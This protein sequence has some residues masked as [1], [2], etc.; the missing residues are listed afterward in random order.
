MLCATVLGVGYSPIMPGTMGTLAAVPLAIG[1]IFVGV[2]AL[3][4]RELHRRISEHLTEGQSLL[5]AARQQ[6]DAVDKLRQQAFQAFDS[7]RL[8]DGERTWAQALSLA[9]EN[10]KALGRV[11]QVFEGVLTLDASSRAARDLLAETLYQRAL[12]AERDRR[13]AQLED[14]LQ[15]LALYDPEG[16]WLQRHKAPGR[17]QLL[18]EPAGAV[19]QLQRYEADAA[20]QLRLLPVAAPTAA[21]IEQLALA[22]G[23]Y[24]LT[25]RAPE[26]A[27]VRYPFV[28]GRDEALRLELALPRAA[29]VPAGFVYVPPG[30]FDFGTT[31]DEPSRR[32]FLSTVPL[33]PVRTAGFLIARSETTFG[34]WLRFLA[35]LPPAERAARAMKVTKGSVSGAVEL[36]EVPGGGWLLKLQPG[37]Q[38]LTAK[39]GEPLLYPGRKVR[40]RVDWQ[41]LPVGGIS[42]DDAQAYARWLATTGQVPGARLCDEYEWERAARGADEREF[43]HGG[44]LGPQDANFDQTYARS[45][46]EMG[47]DEVGSHPASRSPFGLDDMAGNVFEWTTS[48]LGKDELLVRGGGYFFAAIAAR[49]TNRTMVDSSF[50]DPNV[51][52]RICAA[53]PLPKE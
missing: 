40:Q 51:G 22:P 43:P 17:L 46:L 4:Q 45:T 2:R 49:V 15:R 23:S 11:S 16:A 19:V 38:P 13:G 25:L 32:T 7:Q 34:D 41:K 53:A 48:R 24:L 50:R 33:H 47:P 21:P 20:Q 5:A 6:G 18:T 8:E 44:N 1:A 14:L 39:Q 42:I 30:R 36:S 52:V 29:A 37:S 9:Q 35:A 26:R 27:E 28:I 12:A 31:A 10:D 3:N